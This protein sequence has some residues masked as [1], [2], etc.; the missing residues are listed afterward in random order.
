[1]II[2][3]ATASDVQAIA[4]LHMESWR[5]AYADVLPEAYLEAPIRRDLQR[6]WHG[7]D[8]RGDDILLVAEAQ[9][10]LG[11]IAVWCRPD[12]FIDNLHVKPS[13]RCQ[14]IGTALMQAAARR[15]LESGHQS[16][17]LWVFKANANA[18]DFYT[19]LG[20]ETTVQADK[21]VFGHHVP[22]QRMQWK[23]LS[24]IAERCSARFRPLLAKMARS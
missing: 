18:I 5:D 14:K 8:V 21:S 3:S 16:A 24:V 23:D 19:R 2:R 11:F 20:A 22:S 17:Y 12:P 13:H 7:I 4:E 15:L 6:Y 1:M 10:T 9:S